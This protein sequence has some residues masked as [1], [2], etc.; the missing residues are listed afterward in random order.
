MS[1]AR[2]EAS[3][4]ISG[5]VEAAREVRRDRERSRTNA[6]CG[7][8]ISEE[9]LRRLSREARRFL[10]DAVDRMA[11]S[12]RAYVRTLKVAR[13]IADLDGSEVVGESH[14]AEA[15]QYRSLEW[16]EAE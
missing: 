2:S 6:N 16:K 12:A 13:T 1:S 8:G 11:L 9:S 15:A 14:V 7:A 5:R 10:E 4:D 3:A